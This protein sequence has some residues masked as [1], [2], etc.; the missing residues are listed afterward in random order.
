MPISNVLSAPS[1]M[2][3]TNLRPKVPSRIPIYFD[4]A[5]QLA[6][7][8]IFFGIKN[9]GNG[10]EIF[11]KRNVCMVEDGANCDAE[12]SIAR[13]AMMP[14]LRLE[15]GYAIRLA[16]RTDRRP[17]PPDRF[18]MSEASGPCRESFVDGSE[19]FRLDGYPFLGRL[20]KYP[21]REA[22]VKTQMATLN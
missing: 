16:I 6:S 19:I 11:L 18:Y 3:P 22:V 13:V 17:L 8:D 21:A 10:Q 20:G 1:A 4:I 12:G 9:E 7:T 14:L 2:A 15:A 5:G